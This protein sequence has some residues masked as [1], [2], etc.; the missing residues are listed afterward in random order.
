MSR[1]LL[2]LATVVAGTED[3][4]EGLHLLQ[5]HAGKRQQQHS[6]FTMFRE[7]DSPDDEGPRAEAPRGSVQ[8]DYDA[9]GQDKNEFL[10]LRFNKI[11]YRN[12]G[13]LGPHTDSPHNVRYSNVVRLA[14]GTKIDMIL[15]S[16]NFKTAKPRKVGIYGASAVVNILNGHEVDFTARFVDQD[17][18]PA[19]LGPFHISFLDLDT[20]KEGGQEELTIGGFTSSYLLDNTELT[21]VEMADGRTKFIAGEP[22]VG[23]DN[24]MDPLM[25][26]DVQAARTVALQFP[27]GLDSFQFSYKVG[28]VAYDTYNSD[29]TGRHFLISG[30]TSLYFC[31]VEPV[32]MDFNLATVA[33]SNLGGL[34][35]DFDAPRALR[36]N[37]IAAI[38]NDQMIDLTVVNTTS[39]DPA[40]T[41]NNGLNGEFA[42]VNIRGGS[43]TRF[44][45]Q[46]LKH[47][48]DDPVHMDW[49]MLS[50]F[51][52]DEAKPK[53]NKKT[54]QI[55]PQYRE[56]LE[57]KGFATHFIT[58]HSEVQLTQLG[59]KWYQY[60][61]STKGSGKDNPTDPMALTEQ[62][63]NR[64]VTFMFHDISA[65]DARFEAMKPT[66]TG[67]NFLFAGKSSV[68]FC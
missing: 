39:Y 31:E 30:L 68:V 41:A 46:F 45:F 47:G 58:E 36:F 60:T 56:T 40:N 1:T 32:S 43:T 20:G 50:M 29:T 15:E 34:G 9:Q 66:K 59:A 49:T 55:R 52:L 7:E 35:P 2:A 5:T 51:D 27:G 57:V 26:T 33:Y 8:A 11:K 4:S 62:Q 53:K 54:G 63:K 19:R 14:D 37:N 28:K 64:A 67:R 38:A 44:R 3:R 61:S 23:A 24:P 65:F 16:D 48:T 42:Q 18:K 17:D 12:L 6:N 13:G 21:K 10:N 25:L 22:G